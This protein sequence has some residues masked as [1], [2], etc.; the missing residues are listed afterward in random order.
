MNSKQHFSTLLEEINTA[1]QALAFPETPDELYEPCRYVLAAGGKRIRPVTLLLAA[2]MFGVPSQKAMPAALAV[3]VFHN[4]TLVHDDIMDQADTRRG[5]ATVHKKWDENIAILSGDLLM[6]LA[7]D[8]LAQVEGVNTGRLIRRFHRMLMRLCE[9]QTLDMA[10]E[11]REVVTEAEYLDMIS[12]KTAA[13]LACALAMGGM[14]GGASSSEVEALEKV[15]EHVGLGFQIQDDLLDL[16]AEADFGK[17]KGGDLLQGKRTWMLIQALERATGAERVWLARIP[18]R[19]LSL[20]EIPE[21][22]A[23]L[24]ALGIIEDTK[25]LALSHYQQ[26]FSALEALPKG[27]A[28]NTL[29]WTIEQMK[30]RM[31]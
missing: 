14:I 26:A 11:A 12:G 23:R 18:A 8:L 2:E 25:N 21:A 29:A 7:Y 28:W 24:T 13:L 27:L 3:E 17:I 19:Q 22:E 20:D 9:G 31:T 1:I 5:R 16:T 4:F 15:G 6:G 10:F 30:S